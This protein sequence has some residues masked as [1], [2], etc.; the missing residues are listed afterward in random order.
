MSQDGSSTAVHGGCRSIFAVRHTV[1]VRFSQY[2][3]QNTQTFD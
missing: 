1:Y 2:V 3:V